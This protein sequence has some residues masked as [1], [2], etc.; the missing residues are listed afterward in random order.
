[1]VEPV[2]DGAQVCEEAGRARGGR[3]PR[4]SPGRGE[5][6][7]DPRNIPGKLWRTAFLCGVGGCGRFLGGAC[8]TGKWRQ[9]ESSPACRSGALGRWA[10]RWAGVGGLQLFRLTA[11]GAGGA[12]SAGKLGL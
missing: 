3:V 11:D 9:Q 5:G 8:R 12:G 1:M 10:G 2:L 7:Q 4:R 6:A